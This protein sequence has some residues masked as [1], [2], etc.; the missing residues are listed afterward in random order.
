[1]IADHT[2]CGIPVVCAV[3]NWTVRRWSSAADGSNNPED[4]WDFG[5]VDLTLPLGR[6]A[7]LDAALAPWHSREVVR[8]SALRAL[9][10]L[11]L[12]VDIVE[13]FSC[14][15]TIIHDPKAPCRHANPIFSA[16]ACEIDWRTGNLRAVIAG[17]CEVWVLCAGIWRQ[18]TP[19]DML[20][21][22]A[23]YE[24]NSQSIGMT[25]Q[26]AWCLQ[27]E[28]LNE[29]TQWH[30]PPLGLGI[31]R[32]A[33]VVVDAVD[34]VI[35]TSDGARLDPTRAAN[36]EDWLSRGI[37]DEHERTNLPHP[38]GDLWVTSTLRQPQFSRS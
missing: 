16:A 23:R 12:S 8:R 2:N 9:D 26:Q 22:A 11:T 30:R 34:G 33:T 5:A 32:F 14:V 19:S 7:V 31:G 3:A 28:L 21:S 20:E 17:D 37:H 38:H 25:E 36:M 13:G 27:R 10:A 15:E 6:V 35:V 18:L 24:Y 29:P 1:M 4:S